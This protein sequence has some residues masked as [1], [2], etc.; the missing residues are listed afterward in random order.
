MTD[1]INTETLDCSVCE[2]CT[3]DRKQREDL[4]RIPTRGAVVRFSYDVDVAVLDIDDA[5][6]KIM[7]RVPIRYCPMCG[8]KLNTSENL[9]WQED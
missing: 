4:F 5:T 2:Y 3:P 1:Q 9:L 7:Y 8:R 6:A